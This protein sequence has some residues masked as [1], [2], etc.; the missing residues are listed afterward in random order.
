MIIGNKPVNVILSLGKD[1]FFKIW[2][3][4][5]LLCMHAVST[6]TTEAFSMIFQYEKN[7]VYI[8]T[9]REDMPVIKINPN[10]SEE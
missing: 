10:P 1:G 4:E 2:N 8:G 3:A 7:L 6:Q 5:S 9:N